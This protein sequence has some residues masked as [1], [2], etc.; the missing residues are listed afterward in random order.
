[1]K[2]RSHPTPTQSGKP[3]GKDDT[4]KAG[5]AAKA[6]APGSFFAFLYSPPAPKSRNPD[7]RS[8]IAGTAAN[9]E[10]DISAPSRTASGDKS[11]R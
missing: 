4:M 8:T 3:G 10:D 11:R 6:S 1:M 2:T 9:K 5:H 7:T